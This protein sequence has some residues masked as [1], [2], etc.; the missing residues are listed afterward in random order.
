[1]AGPSTFC[2]SPSSAVLFQTRA[3]RWPNP[4]TDTGI[5][6]VRFTRPRCFYLTFHATSVAI[7]PVTIICTDTVSYCSCVAP[8]DTLPFSFYH[9]HH[10]RPQKIHIFFC[11]FTTVVSYRKSL[12]QKLHRHRT[13]HDQTLS[14]KNW[15]SHHHPYFWCSA[16]V[17]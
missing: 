10:N 4:W 17:L 12:T 7:I 5:C 16:L 1:M 8:S 6:T 11:T 14:C 9:N 13:L 2:W 3:S 15:N